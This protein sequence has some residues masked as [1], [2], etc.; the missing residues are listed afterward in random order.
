LRDAALLT[1]LYATGMRV[2]EVVSLSVDDIDLDNQVLTCPG[3]DDETRQLPFDQN[4]H[5]FW[6]LIL[7]TA[8]LIWSKK[9]QSGPFL[10]HRGQQLT[11]QGLWLIIKAYA[12]Q[13]GLE[14]GSYAPYAA[15]QLC[16][17]QA[18]QRL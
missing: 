9:K 11:R 4:T 7:M 12:R 3:D 5:A 17:P 2:T 15:P 10:N 6:K 18:K 14:S 16:C 13:V 8:V 1:V